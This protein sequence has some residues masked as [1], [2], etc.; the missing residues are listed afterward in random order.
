MDV[1]VLGAG[2][3]GRQIARVCARAGHDVALQDEDANLVMDAVDDVERGLD[4]AL[5]ADSFD[6][7]P[8]D[9]S[10]DSLDGT[11]G[12]EAAVGDAA[13]VVET[14]GGDFETG[15]GDFETGGGDVSAIRERLAAAE[16]LTDRDTL[17]GV[18]S[19]PI[20][21]TAAAAGLQHPDRAVG[22]HFRD[23][24]ES[25]LVEVV[26]ADQTARETAESAVDFVN[27]LDRHPI[28]V[29]DAPGEAATRLALA[30]ELEAM[31]LVEAGV[32]GV[33][34]ADDALTEGYGV[35]VG[36][37]ERADR[38]GL[39]DRL[40]T[41]ERLAGDL[42]PR[43]EPPAILRDLVRSGHTGLAGGEG[44]YVWENDEPVES[45]LPAPDLAGRTPDPTDPGR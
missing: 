18:G 16:E 11:T 4:E 31:R 35:P 15:G 19:G 9:A 8:D 12:L 43:F 2:P 14:G 3:V 10:L 41:L 39:D 32:A 44:F 42:G 29:A 22:V 38:A 20:S 37:L 28:L 1:A 7:T 40:S 24:L 34:A 25:P 30:Q 27:G 21:V 5:A 36:P 6:A 33:E 17:I 23:P 45:T 26:V 13:V